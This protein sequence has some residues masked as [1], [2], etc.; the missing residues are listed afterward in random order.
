MTDL[1]GSVVAIVT[2]F[3]ENGSIDYTS[4]KG[5]LKFHLKNGTDGIVVCGTT[6]ETP[7]L[8]DEE[9]SS[10][11]AFTVK[12]VSHQIPVIAGVGSNS[13][14]KTLHNIAV[15]ES[16]HVDGLLVVSPYYNKPTQQGLYRHFEMM[17]THTKQFKFFNNNI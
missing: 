4:Y 10:L 7:T 2:P 16:H 15:A 3:N 1:K 11:I 5:L 12:E 8:S 14:D 13:T 9:Y 17:A 6:G